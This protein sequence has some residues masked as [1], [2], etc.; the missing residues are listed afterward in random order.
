MGKKKYLEDGYDK[1]MGGK[2]PDCRY[3]RY[4]TTGSKGSR[5]RYKHCLY[6]KRQADRRRR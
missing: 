2:F 5:C 6:R 4:H 1:G 3:C